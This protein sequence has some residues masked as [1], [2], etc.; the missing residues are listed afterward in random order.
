M[1]KS[2]GWFFLLFLNTLVYIPVAIFMKIA[3]ILGL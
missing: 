2:L 3:E 1:I